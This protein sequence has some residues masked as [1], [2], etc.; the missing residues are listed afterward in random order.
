VHGVA[1]WNA[2]GPAR[3]DA[4]QVSGAQ[5]AGGDVEPERRHPAAE[6][7]P[8]GGRDD[9]A[10]RREHGAHRDPVRD[11]EVGHRRDAADDVRLGRDALELCDRTIG[12]GAAPDPNR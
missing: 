3:E 11:V 6:I 12:R 2:G 8:E 5:A 10:A 7:T 1:D 4:M 9:H